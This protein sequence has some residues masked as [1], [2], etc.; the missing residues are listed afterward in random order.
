MAELAISI[1][2]LHEPSWRELMKIQARF[3]SRADAVH[4]YQRCRELF[5]DELGVN[6]DVTTTQLYEQLL[7]D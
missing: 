4:T 1:E 5:R 3:G 6:P 7:S 2:P